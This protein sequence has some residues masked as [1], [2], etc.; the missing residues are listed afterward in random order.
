MPPRS[1]YVRRP[2]ADARLVLGIAQEDR[3]DSLPN[4]RHGRSCSWIVLKH[5]DDGDSW[6]GVADVYK[7]A[8]MAVLKHHPTD[9][10]TGTQL[11]HQDGST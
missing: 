11:A 9:D 4:G 7:H 10:L 8:E 1:L 2:E 3:L 6:L 5:R